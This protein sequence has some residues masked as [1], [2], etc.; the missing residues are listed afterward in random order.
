MNFENPFDD[1][2]PAK[3]KKPKQSFSQP[4]N[5]A[6][7]RVRQ[8]TGTGG[9]RTHGTFRQLTFRLSEEDFD[10]IGKWADFLE[11]SK[12]DVKRWIVGRGLSALEGGER[13]EFEVV[14]VKKLKT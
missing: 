14:E 1:V 6:P 5:V 13:P 10:A 4:L 3:K 8:A 12:E 2:H 11:I 7:E 9:S